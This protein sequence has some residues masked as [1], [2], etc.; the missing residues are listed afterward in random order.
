M[1]LTLKQAVTRPA[2]ANVLQQ[3][4]RFDDFVEQYNRERPHQALGMKVPADLYRSSSRVYRGLEDLAYPFHDWS[5]VVTHCGRIC[6]K[7]LG[8]H[9]K[10]DNLSTPQKRQLPGAAETGEFYFVPSSVRKSVC[11]LVRQ[12]RGPHLRTCA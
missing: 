3:Q 9:F 6:F 1:H 8:G 11:T 5:V 10:T 2:A 4:A 7:G 12:L